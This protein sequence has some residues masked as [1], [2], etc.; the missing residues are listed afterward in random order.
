MKLF[1]SILAK[2]ILI[3]VLNLFHIQFAI[4]QSETQQVDTLKKFKTTPAPEW[5]NLFYRNSGWF[6]A[7]GIFEMTLR[8]KETVGAGQSDS[9]LM[10]FS[11]TMTGEVVGDTAVR[12][13]KMINNSFAWITGL[14]PSAETVRIFYN[15]SKEGEPINYVN[16]QTPQSKQDE[17]YWFG[18]GFVNQED[19]NSINIFGY[20]TYDRSSASWDFELRGVTLITIPAGGNFSKQSQVDLPL[21]IDLPIG[22]GT[23]GAAVYVNTKKA[24][25]PKPDGYLYVYGVLDPDKKLIV[26]RVKPADVKNISQW[27]FWNGSS[28]DEHIANVKPVTD[29]VSNELSITPLKDGRYLLVFQEDGIG[30]HTAI[31]IGKTPVGP[32][33]P[34][35]RIWKVPEIS[36]PPGI[37]PYNAKAHP[38]LSSGNRLLI[39]YN[40]I[41]LDYF[42]DILRYPHMY[43]P[44][45]FWLEI[46]D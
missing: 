3:S 31:R 1:A 16:P 7:D 24:G 40:T 33:G 29:R 37:I 28:W 13:F 46:T 27:Q 6:G 15:K 30:A 26:A 45:F 17:Y 43:R 23:F 2:L 19:K 18:D 22:K 4:S 35:Q 12:N 14:K 38:V 34:L 42:K 44:R 39:S 20:R 9:V 36:E 25:A 21:F 41:S 10:Y 32:F 8:G 5:T 11:D